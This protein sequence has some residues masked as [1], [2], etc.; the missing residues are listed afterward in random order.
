MREA[1]DLSQL[2]STTTTTKKEGGDLRTQ[3]LEYYWARE[4]QNQG[5]SIF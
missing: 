2:E 4:I 1:R 3:K 5:G